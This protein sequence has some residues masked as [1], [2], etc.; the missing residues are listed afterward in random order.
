MKKQIK[1]LVTIAAVLIAPIAGAA[2]ADPHLVV[3]SALWG[4]GPS[5]TT[6]AGVAAGLRGP[7]GPVMDDGAVSADPHAALQQ[8]FFAEGPSYE[9]RDGAQRGLRGAKGPVMEKS[10]SSVSGNAFMYRDYFPAD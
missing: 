1:N 4:D 3:Q 7:A 10:A 9:L 2:S 8:V 6:S 5:Y